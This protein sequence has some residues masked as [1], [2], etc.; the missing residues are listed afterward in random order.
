VIFP[1]NYQK[2]VSKYGIFM[3]KN[4]FIFPTDIHMKQ[5]ACLL[6]CLIS[7]L[8]FAQAKKP[9]VAVMSFKGSA[10]V[11][12]DESDLLTD[13]L[14]VELFNT[15]TVDVMERDQMQAILKEQG[16]QKSGACTDEGCMVEMG[17]ILGVQKLI[18]GSIGKIGSM[19]LVNARIIDITTAKITRSVSDDVK[20]KLEDVVERIPALA[21]RLCGAQSA[22]N[23]DSLGQEKPAVAPAAIDCRNKVFI[24]KIEFPKTTLGFALTNGEWQSVYGKLADGLKKCF[25][26]DL[27]IAGVEQLSQA[28]D[29]GAPVI[30]PVLNSYITRPTKLGQK[31]GTLNL[32]LALYESWSA[33]EPLC[34]F[35]KEATGENHWGD[36]IP[37]SNAI[38]AVA[39]KL[40]KDLDKSDCVARINRKQ[41]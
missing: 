15:G 7:F 25:S 2:P 38:E 24:E 4:T 9:T 23:A 8:C 41:K 28:A 31:E 30:R 20:G 21:A 32:S 14:R 29:C 36:R 10:G 12:Q 35:G 5:T 6:V 22:Q 19:Y 26:A 17:E 18:T 27:C 37:F 11:T 13:R 16:F 34:V 33:K 40:K 3:K 1:K 39:D